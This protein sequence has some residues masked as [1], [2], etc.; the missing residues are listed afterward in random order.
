MRVMVTGGAGFIGSHLA[1]RLVSSG[2]DVDVVDDLSSG[3]L[4]NLSTA[5]SLRGGKLHF[6]QID[7]KDAGVATLVERRQ[8]EVVFHLAA[9]SDVRMSMVDPI[10]DADANILGSLRI[11]D[12]SRRASVQKVV[13]AAS[14]GIYGAVP[15]D[16]I[17]ISEDVAHRPESNY[18]LSKDTVLRYLEIYRAT[19]DLEYTALILANVYGPRQGAR[20]E[21]GVVSVFA[22]SLLAGS[23]VTIYGDGTQTRDFVY[24]DDV[25]DAFYRAMESGGGTQIN[26]GTG[27]EISIN[28]LYAALAVLTGRQGAEPAYG[29]GVAG[30]I[31][32]SA[33]NA[34]RAG[35]YLRWH[36]FTKIEDGLRGVVSWM[37]ATRDL[38]E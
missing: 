23:P 3:S 16:R 21:A 12:A 26:I 5:R 13:F 6:H 34:R 9:R 1:E 33:L 17:P 29:Q 10:A 38:A 20:G 2:I 25:V 27:R 32:R 11:L 24:V 7:V 19:Y 36:P 4:A 30:E 31:M 8:P 14:A 22:R 28:E 15:E 37:E 18:G 35:W